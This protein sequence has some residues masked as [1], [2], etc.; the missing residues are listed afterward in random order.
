VLVVSSFVRSVS[1]HSW[2]EVD[3]DKQQ[4]CEELVPLLQR[5]DLV[6]FADYGSPDL[7]FCLDRRG[8]LLHAEESTPARLGEII[9]Q[10]ASVLV[11]QNSWP[12]RPAVAPLVA[13]KRWLAFRVD[14]GVAFTE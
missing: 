2:Y 8:W 5:S 6:A 7:L 9:R 11:M 3:S 12:A 14:E 4:F 1:F 10:G 13:T